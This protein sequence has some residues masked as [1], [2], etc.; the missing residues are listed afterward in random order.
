MT[1]KPVADRKRFEAM[2]REHHYGLL[3]CSK[4]E[5]EF[6]WNAALAQQPVAKPGEDELRKRWM[7]NGQ[8]LMR[9]AAEVGWKDNGEGALEFLMRRSYEQGAEDAQRTATGEIHE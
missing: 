2:W 8:N 5:A 4:G 3:G 7:R 1:D 6:I 9:C